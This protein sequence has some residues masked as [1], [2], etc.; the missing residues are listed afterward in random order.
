MGPFQGKHEDSA[1]GSI[2]HSKEGTGWVPAARGRDKGLVWGS[3][4]EPWQG[5]ETV[6]GPE[7]ASHPCEVPTH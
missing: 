1:R 5:F 2:C 7:G 4:R 6:P 3:V